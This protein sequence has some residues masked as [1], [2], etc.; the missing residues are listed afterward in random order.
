MDPGVVS[1]NLGPLPPTSTFPTDGR[2]CRA[3]NSPF[4]FPLFQADR[5]LILKMFEHMPVIAE[6]GKIPLFH[7][8]DAGGALIYR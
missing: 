8:S 1:F 4:A 2:N 5:T 3:V 6:S 7:S